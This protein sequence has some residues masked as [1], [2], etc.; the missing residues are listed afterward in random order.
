MPRYWSISLQAINIKMKFLSILSKAS[1]HQLFSQFFPLQALNTS[2]SIFYPANL[3]PISLFPQKAFFAPPFYLW[4][5]FLSQGTWILFYTPLWLHLHR[6][7]NKKGFWRM[8][9][10]PARL[11]T[12]ETCVMIPRL[13]VAAPTRRLCAGLHKWVCIL[14]CY[15]P[16]SLG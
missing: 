9:R 13:Q 3:V 5:F 10:D 1:W 16:S 15:N 11:Q 8:C 4:L 12:A 6:S 7:G 2:S 14:S